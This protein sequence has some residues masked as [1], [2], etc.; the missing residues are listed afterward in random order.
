M[1]TRE[2]LKRIARL[3]K[4]SVAAGETDAL[5]SDMSDIIKIAQ[6]IDDA[7]LSALDCGSVNDAAQLR[8]DSVAPPL[9]AG[10]ILSNAAQ[11][12]DGYFAGIIGSGKSE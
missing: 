11:K 7:D 3:A 1:V 5:L 8:E 10:V 9:P 2:E 12:R 6:S 4:L